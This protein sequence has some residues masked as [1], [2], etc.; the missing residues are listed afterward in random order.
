MKVKRSIASMPKELRCN[1]LRCE[2]N[3]RKLVTS[4]AALASPWGS[5]LAKNR[6]INQVSRFGAAGPIGGLAAA[7]KDIRHTRRW[8]YPNTVA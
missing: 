4:A 1:N 5:V 3:N 8:L 2:S 7:G 6:L